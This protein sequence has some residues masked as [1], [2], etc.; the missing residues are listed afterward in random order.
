M[1][2][3]LGQSSAQCAASLT[4]ASGVGAEAPSSLLHAI[5]GFAGIALFGQM[6]L[7]RLLVTVGLLFVGAFGAYRMLAPFKSVQ[8][9]LV[10]LIVYVAAP[11]PYNALFEGSWG[12]LV[13]YAAMP[14]VAK[15]MAMAAGVAPFVDDEPQLRRR[16]A[17]TL[18]LGLIL[19]LAALIEP[20]RDLVRSRRETSHSD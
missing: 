13:A 3:A 19:A 2:R 14:W 9:Q 7:L 18:V 15:R 11:L 6:G 5:L 8:A 4:P 10:A 1:A 20:V 17:D 12:G 16:V